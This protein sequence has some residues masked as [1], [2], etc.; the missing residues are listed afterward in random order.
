MLALHHFRARRSGQLQG[1]FLRL[2]RLG[3]TIVSNENLFERGVSAA[4][5]NSSLII[6]GGWDFL[7]DS[8]M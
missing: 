3:R 7:R 4:H 5:H 8:L 1:S 6:G 2:L